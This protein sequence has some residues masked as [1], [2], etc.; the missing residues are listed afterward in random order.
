MEAF[1]ESS[2]WG[3]VLSAVSSMALMNYPWAAINVPLM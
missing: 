3:D 1:S 2:R